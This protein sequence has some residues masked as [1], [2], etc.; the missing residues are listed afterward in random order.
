MDR[1]KECWPDSKLVFLLRHP[2]AIARSRS[3]LQPDDADEAKN[4]DLIRRYCEALEDARQTYDGVT[5]RYEEL[6]TEP[7]GTLRQVCEHLGVR[8]ESGMLDY[9]SQ[10]HGR[11]KAGLGDWADKIKTGQVQPPEPPPPPEDIPEALRPMC[12]TWGYLPQPAGTPAL[13]RAEPARVTWRR[14]A[15][16]P[17]A[18]ALHRAALRLVAALRPALARPRHSPGPVRI[19]LAHAWGMGGTIRTTFNLAA[20]LGRRHDVEIV[21]VLRRRERPF[22]A[23]PGGVGVSALDD[24]RA[25]RGPLARALGALPSLLVHPEDYSYPWCSLWTDVVLVRRL[26][27]LRG[28]VLVTTRPAFNLLAAR[29]VHRSVTLVGQEHMNFHS[30]RPRLAA[31]IRRGYP[32]PGRAGGAHRGRPA[33]LRAAA[34]RRADARGADPQH[35]GRAGRRHRRAGRRGGGRG[36]AAEHA[37]GVRPADRRLGAGGRAPP[38]VAAAHLRLR[39]R[40]RAA[41]A[42]DRRARAGRAGRADGPHAGGSARPWPRARCSCSAPASRASAW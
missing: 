41:R 2:A 23:L 12:V 1:I 9:G 20:E 16:G 36:R 5:I 7:E 34:G 13:E 19:L 27:A 14:R 21:S 30:H 39:P 28:G 29:L 35:G 33:R 3:A 17:P 32:A 24:R 26:R 25:R 40:A 11:F 8:W 37:E 18:V 42:A 4:V 6:T 10:D 38:G 22:F 31:D 15:L